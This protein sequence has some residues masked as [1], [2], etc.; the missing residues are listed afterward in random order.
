MYFNPDA[1]VDTSSIVRYA[2][3]SGTYERLLDGGSWPVW[4]SDS[5]RFLFVGLQGEVLLFDTRS[6]ES[7]AVLPPGNIAS[8]EGRRLSI[9]DD[10]RWISL[11][12]TTTEGDI[13]LLSFE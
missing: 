2:F 7:H 1:T 12:D 9:T 8:L 11:I 10:D 13:W 6:G 5:Q 3:D 4:L